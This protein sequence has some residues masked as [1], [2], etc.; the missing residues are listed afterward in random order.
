MMK[1]KPRPFPEG[2]DEF[3]GKTGMKPTMGVDIHSNLYYNSEFVDGLDD[4]EL[5]GVLIHETCLTPE[6]LV[7]TEDGLKQIRDI[8]VG[9][10]V[11]NQNG[12]FTKVLAKSKRGYKGKVYTFKSRFGLPITFTEDHPILT[13][14]QYNYERNKG[15][16]KSLEKRKTPYIKGVKYCSFR[17]YKARDINKNDVLVMHL[18]LT[19]KIRI[20][21][22]FKTR[23]KNEESKSKGVYLDED[24]AY[25]L[26][27]FVGDGSL[28]KIRKRG[29]W[30][31]IKNKD[32]VERI[33]TLTLSLKDDHK[34]LM[35]IIRNKFFRSPILTGIKNKKANRISFSSKSLA[36][37]LRKNFYNQKEKRI[38]RWLLSEKTEIINS[39]IQGLHDADGHTTK[40][41][42]SCITSV[43]NGVY[44]FLPLLFLKLRIIPA[45]S[46]PKIYN[47]NYKVPY[48]ISYTL[49]RQVQTG[50]FKGNHFIF[51]LDEKEEK[52]YE[53][54]VYNL[55]TESHTYCVP[56]F[57]VHNCH[58]FLQHHTRMIKRNHQIANIAMDI[59][60][61]NMLLQNG[62][63]LPIRMKGDKSKAKFIIPKNNEFDLEP[64]GIKYIIK[65][66][67][68]KPVEQVY[69]E[70]I[71]KLTHNNEALQKLLEG[72][73]DSHIFTEQEEKGEDKGGKG[74]FSGISDEERKKIE[75]E[76]K[77]TLV[78][79]AE[80]CRRSRGTL[81]LGIDRMFDNLTK[82]KLDWKSMLQRFVSSGTL[83]DF[84]WQKPSRRSQAVGVYLPSMKRENVD[85]T[86]VIDTS[87]SVNNKDL[88]LFISEIIGLARSFSNVKLRVISCD[89][90]VQTDD[91]VANGSIERIKRLKIK[92]GG[93]TS[94]TNPLN[95]IKEKYPQTKLVIF[96]TDGYG[97]KIQKKDYN[98]RILWV[99]NDE[100]TDELI[101]D[102]GNIV[103]MR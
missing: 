62:F 21:K 16:R 65:N 75:Q 89:H 66:I 91:E 33:V 48:T 4:D 69:D 31:E 97:D 80:H 44:S 50:I 51:P 42:R 22:L 93:G 70:I 18:P 57:I 78:E 35:E 38:P 34:R 82:S 77:D 41:G 11:Y 54:E 73:F 63:T 45:I 99:L 71:G 67:D 5:R 88:N 86:V 26:G 13:L 2:M 98:F 53:G 101:K 68:K 43:S 24:V 74:I 60:V 20:K 1:M 46:R 36:K 29:E 15:F 96:I 39:F 47:P 58:L 17:F 25:F 30:F 9:E 10:K 52:N 28:T 64:F 49:N 40:A 84:T 87:G 12:Y 94:F 100:G 81:P 102:T 3:M 79:A 19:E 56:F 8:E 90:A 37:F 103:R 59:V 6:S 23:D 55:E 7:L 76:W 95:Y 14:K 85:A 61:N 72:Q 92:G 27:F 83:K 32:K